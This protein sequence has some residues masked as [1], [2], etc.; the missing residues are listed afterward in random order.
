M[1]PERRRFWWR[2][3]WVST[4]LL[5]A[6]TFTPL[7]IPTGVARPALAGVPYTLWTGIL[8]TV[9]LVGLTYGATVFYPPHESGSEEHP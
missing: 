3:C 1:T 6:L 9:A 7:V 5:C 8:I 2:A 4:A